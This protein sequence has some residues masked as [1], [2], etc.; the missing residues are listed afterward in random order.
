V[1]RP[2][3]KRKWREKMITPK[4][5]FDIAFVIL[6]YIT[7]MET[8]NLVSSIKKNIDTPNY[9]IIIVDNYSPNKS[10]Y[11][12]KKLYSTDKSIDVIINNEN[13]GF[14]RGNNVGIRHCKDNYIIKYI[15]CLN[16]DT[17][18]IQKDFISKVEQEYSLSRAAV[19]GPRIILKNNSIQASALRLKSI[20]EYQN[21]YN[22]YLKG[23]IPS[24]KINGTLES[25]KKKFPDLYTKYS[26]IK[27]DFYGNKLRFRQED[28]V[29][30]GCCLI[31]TEVFFE[32]LSGFNE[33]TFLFREEELLY[34]SIKSNHLLSVYNPH[35]R[36]KHLE[37]AATDSIVSTSEEKKKFVIKNQIE[38]LSILI[39][40]MKKMQEHG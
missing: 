40:E 16:N 26:S 22:D 8:Q 37:D 28:V 18:L 12:L 35:I 19:I 9:K 3:A 24:N 30:H 36:I 21:E 17:I 25:I 29:L 33:Q 15:C 4:Y 7:I 10:G 27:N 34:L 2:L 20:G 14:A 32:L 1:K 5:E 6:H 23:E 11:E 38:S 39:N 31:F 13:L